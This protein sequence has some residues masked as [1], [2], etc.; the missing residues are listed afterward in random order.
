MPDYHGHKTMADGSTIPLTEDEARN[1][2]QAAAA[3]REKRA[4]NM[5]AARDALTAINRAQSRMNELGWW[6]GGGLRVRR[7]DECAV[8]Q[9]GSTGIWRGR[10]DSEGKYVHFCDSVSDPRQCWLKPLSDLTDDEREWMQ[11][12]GRSEAEAYSAMLDRLAS[13]ED[14]SHAE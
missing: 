1:L 5:P 10:V 2:W 11:K 12:C 9:S 4:Q 3:A 14:Q 8:A 7:G 6:L 13:Q